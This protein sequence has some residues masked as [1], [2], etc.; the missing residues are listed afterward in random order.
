MAILAEQARAREQTAVDRP[1]EQMGLKGRKVVQA[2]KVKATSG[3]QAW[4]KER[5]AV[6]RPQEQTGLKK[7]M[8]VKASLEAD[9][10]SVTDPSERVPLQDLP[11]MDMVMAILRRQ[12]RTGDLSIVERT[13]SKMRAKYRRGACPGRPSPL[14]KLGLPCLAHVL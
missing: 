5:T 9:R 1:K 2:S 6:G 13:V 10:P 3:K 11:V 4:A 8:T 12:A 7:R 14:C